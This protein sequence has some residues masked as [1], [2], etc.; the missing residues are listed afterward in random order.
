MRVG[1]AN[2]INGEANLLR[3]LVTLAE[4]QVAAYFSAPFTGNVKFRYKTFGP[5]PQIRPF[6]AKWVCFRR[7]VVYG[8][9]S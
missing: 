6:Q 1:R 4:Y 5:E 7:T 9:I 3:N 2:D 8:M